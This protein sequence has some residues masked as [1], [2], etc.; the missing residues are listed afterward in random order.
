MT[1]PNKITA[2]YCRLSQDDAILGESNSITNQKKML[3]KYAADNGFENC[4]FYVDD[5]YSGISFDNRPA[6]QEMYSEIE[7]CNIGTVITKD[8][9]RFGRN[10]LLV[11]QYLQIIFPQYGVRYIAVNDNVDTIQGDDEFT[12]LRSLFNEWYVRDCSKKIKAV[13]LAQAMR[14]ERVNGSV[15]Y[16][17]MPSHEDKNR[18]IVDERFAPAI[19]DMFRMYAN[20]DGVINIIRHLKACK[21]PKPAVMKKLQNDPGFDVSAIA[22]PYVWCKR[23]INI[24]LD[25][26]VY[27]GHTYTHRSGKASYRSNKKVMYPSNQQFEFLNT[28]KPLVDNDTWNTVQRRKADRPKVNRQ[29]E[30][31]S[32]SGL[33]FCGDCGTRMSVHREKNRPRIYYTC[34]GY[35]SRKERSDQCTTHCI[36]KKIVEA[37]VLDDLLRV[38]SEARNNR[39][40][41]IELCKNNSS[42][43][44]KKEQAAKKLELTKAEKRLAEVKRMFV[45]IYEDNALGKLSDEDYV[46]LSGT[47]K[48][49]QAQLEQTVNELS[50]ALEQIRNDEENTE[51]FLKIVDKYTDI[52]ELTY[53]LLRDFIDKIFIYEKDK[54]N[55]TRRIEIFYNF[56][57]NIS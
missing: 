51:R 7:K 14:G 27:L 36:N 33:L 55:K 56:V 26:P 50:T 1:Q 19:Q 23:S 46:M 8:L 17:Y 4:R 11:G 53:D 38:T 3:E 44:S 45:K 12:E 32:F 42:T 6:F 30:V 16:G 21:Y 52:T 22:D 57:G 18:L 37:V 49:E 15:P 5:G 48:S 9:S 39:E 43:A 31:D 34:E 47:Y 2:L 28:H 35:R 13:K 24:I 20:G 29:S 10:Y 25:N 40:K 54:V 41:F